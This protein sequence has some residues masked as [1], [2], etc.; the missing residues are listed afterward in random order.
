MQSKAT[1]KNHIKLHSIRQSNE[2]IMR[3]FPYIIDIMV[4]SSYYSAELPNP[5][6]HYWFLYKNIRKY[7]FHHIWFIENAILR[8]L[9]FSAYETEHMRK[10]NKLLNNRPLQSTNC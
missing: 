8:M 6:I 10:C 1:I 2:E 5:K 4:Y 9:Y 3:Y 7:I